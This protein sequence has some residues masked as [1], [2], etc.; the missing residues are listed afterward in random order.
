MKRRV[1]FK[2]LNDIIHII[3]S[4]QT[5]TKDLFILGIFLMKLILY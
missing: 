1:T 2:G 5:P 4:R 3:Q